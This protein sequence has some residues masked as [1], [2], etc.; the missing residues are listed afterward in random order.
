MDD[1]V[2]SLLGEE[3]SADI[4]AGRNVGL[5]GH[6]VNCAC[7]GTRLEG[8]QVSRVCTG[9]FLD[10]TASSEFLVALNFFVFILTQ[11]SCSKT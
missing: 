7:L 10:S 3:P 4:I 9:L 11:L 1:G 6:E 5:E 8:A 2:A